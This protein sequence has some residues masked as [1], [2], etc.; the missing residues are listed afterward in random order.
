MLKLL[1]DQEVEVEGFDLHKARRAQVL[2]GSKAIERD[3]IPPNL[4]HVA[5][6]DVAFKEK[7]AVGT[8]VVL[9]RPDW[10]MVD[11]ATA[12]VEARIPYIPTFLSFREAPAI[13]KAFRKLKVKPQLMFV[14]GQGLAHPYRCGLA[15]YVGV[16]L[17]LPTIG[18]ARGRLYGEEV[19]EGGRTLLIDSK[20]GKV[21]GMVVKVRSETKPLYVSVGHK[22]SLE[23][24]VKLVLEATFANK[25]LPE[26][27]MMAH[28]LASREAL[29]L[30]T[31]LEK[32]VVK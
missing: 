1:Y 22:L 5:G 13:F 9:K 2:I 29:L 12:V 30:K 20:D 21:V 32:A 25:A 24:A 31:K 3:I 16:I 18:V 11:E 4:D 23:T 28:N 14:N 8:V 27:L 10:R 7:F 19:V 6:A 17:D 26:P 15:T